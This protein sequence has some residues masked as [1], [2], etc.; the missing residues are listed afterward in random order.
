MKYVLIDTNIFLDMLIDR[1][2]QVSNKLVESFEKLL[3]YDEIK[4]VVPAIVMH[5]TY[6]HI[7]EELDKVRGSLDIAIKNIESLYGVNAYKVDGLNIK[8]YKKKSKKELQDA[9]DMF[10]QNKTAYHTEIIN[11]INKIFQHK[12]TIVIN[13]DDKL[14][15]LCLRRRVY[16]KAPFHIENKDS[17]ADGIITETLINIKDIIDIEKDDKIFFVTGNY[18]DFSESGN[19]ADRDI[20]HTDIIEDL[21]KKAIRD[22]IFYVR[23]FH[24]LIGQSLKTEVA[25]ADLKEN[26]KFDFEDQEEYLMEM[27]KMECSDIM[28]ERGGLSSLSG[29]ESKLQENLPESE[30]SANICG[31]F[32]EMSLIYSQL[33]ECSL[34]YEDELL[35]YFN[36]LEISELE[37]GIEQINVFFDC[38][39]EARVPSSVSGLDSIREWIQLKIDETSA[40]IVLP[41]SINF[42]DTIT[43]VDVEKE[44]YRF[45]LNELQ[46]SPGD[47]D[48]DEI[49]FCI[50]NKVNNEVATGY[51][52]VSYGFVEVDEDG[53]IDDAGTEEIDY[54]TLEIE[55]FL[56]VKV[57]ELEGFSNKQEAMVDELRTIFDL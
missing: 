54:F 35:N 33:E 24:Q 51:V 6:K 27:S 55:G 37:E 38:R 21:I 36:E 25:N 5:E 18:K 12:N 2:N 15:S 19:K 14:I 49:D 52:Q 30:F 22:K 57:K 28:R 29:F 56:E 9:I 42:G 4:V 23:S 16:K 39:H 50:R 48:Q 41:D 45:I 13:D 44:A 34:F 10:D 1:K 53:G 7:D 31:F 3:D 20:L 11:L 8:E 17:L 40:D 46:L 47:G 26:F 32:E 43:F